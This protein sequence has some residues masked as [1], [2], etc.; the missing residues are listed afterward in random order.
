MFHRPLRRA[1]TLIELLVV[2]SIVA[3][4]I[5][6]LLPALSAA[7]GAAESVKCLS[8]LRQIGVIQLVYANDYD[9]Y[10]LCDRGGSWADVYEEQGYWDITEATLCPSEAPE[11]YF[12]RNRTYGSAAR[13]YTR[14]ID[15]FRDT[16]QQTVVNFSTLPGGVSDDYLVIRSPAL[17]GGTP[18]DRELWIRRLDWIADPSYRIAYSDSYAAIPRLQSAFMPQSAGNWGGIGLRHNENANGVAWDGHASLYQNTDLKERGW[19]SGHVRQ[20]GSYT[21]VGF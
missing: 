3:L 20:Q 2:I 10:L 8:N 16:G 9:H 4:L 21:I 5:A 13:S 11:T 19:V 15:L 17:G 7:R 18:Q 12:A 6:I 1:F 14:R